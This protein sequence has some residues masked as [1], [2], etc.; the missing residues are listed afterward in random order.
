VTKIAGKVQEYIEK[1]PKLQKLPK[2]TQ[3]APKKHPK[4]TQKVT[5]KFFTIALVESTTMTRCEV[6]PKDTD[7]AVLRPLRGAAT[8]RTTAL[9]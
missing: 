3:K 5:K 8:F 2:R 6:V 4:S 9:C 7:Y 1:L